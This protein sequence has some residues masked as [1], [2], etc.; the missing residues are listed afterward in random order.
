MNYLEI[1]GTA[2][3]ILYLYLEY[4][5]NVWLWAASIAMPAIYL[6]VYYDA[7]LYADFAI[8]IYY[9]LASLYGLACWLRHR[10]TDHPDSNDNNAIGI[11][12]T[13]RRLRLPLILAAAILFAAIGLTL[14]RLT[15]SNVP[16][17]DAFTTALSIIALWML[18]RKYVEQW[19]VWIVADIACAL[20]YAYKDLWFTAALYL[21]Y[22][23]IAVAG[24]RKWKLLM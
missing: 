4:K 19:L 3:G 1:T 18:A 13:P 12:P 22:A 24:Y 8:S 7:G 15:D 14:S 6:A 9:I 10:S 16:W 23:I 21:A 17:A 11:R 5:A 20:L 2:V